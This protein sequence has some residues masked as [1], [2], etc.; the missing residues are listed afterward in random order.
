V[1]APDVAV[2]GGGI[3]GCSVSALLAERGASVV[4]VEA[5]AIGAGASGRNMGAIQ[6]PFD[7]VL[8][9]L[10]RESLDR[11][12]ALGAED[13]SF[14]LP[15]HPAGVLMIDTDPAAAQRQVER[16]TAL[17]RGL[18]AT[19]LDVEEV[20]AAEPSLA[21]GLAGCLLASTGYP[22]PPASATAAWAR[23]A[24]RR[25]VQ[26][27]VG[28]AAEPWVEGARAR[29]VRLADGSRIAADA[30]L[31]ASGPWAPAH[32][33]PS[34]G[35]QPIARTW[36]VTVQ[37]QLGSAAPRHI[38]EQDAVDAVNRQVNAA[39]QAGALERD[40]DPPSLFTVAS[41]GGMSTIGSTFLPAEPDRERVAKL[42]LERGARYLPAIA[43]ADVSEIRLC[44][45]PQSVD[46]RPFIGPVEGVEGLFVCAGHG[47]WGIS[48]GPGSAALAVAAMLDGAEVSAAL[49]ASRSWGGA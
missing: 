38:V 3:V 25:G 11:Y 47:P 4:L 10:Y 34:G 6:H 14:S 35:W 44:A 9:T 17:E 26:L 2:I 5:T 45:R 16:L 32:V 21:P 48:T 7:P 43:Q 15:E 39:A 23:L 41:A 30:V 1:V 22:I 40:A 28:T 8:T 37:L 13:R 31:V 18:G 42:L 24:E 49:Q 19:F 27:M 12:R 29:G 20:A 33:D 36:G 46:G